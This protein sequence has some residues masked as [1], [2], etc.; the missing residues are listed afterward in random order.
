M[1]AGIFCLGA[2]LVCAPGLAAQHETHEPA[3]GAKPDLSLTTVGRHHHPIQTS[4]AEAQTYFDQGM[5]FIYGF[6]HEEAQRAFEH[7]AALDPASP[8]PLWGVALAVGPNYNLDVDPARE[9]LAYDTIQKALKLA[10]K[11]SQVE[12]DYVAALAV[13]YSGDANPDYKKLGRDYATAMG[14]LSKKY[15]DDL[16]AATL[17]AESLMNLRPWKLWSHEGKPAEGTLEIVRVLE[18]VLARVPNHP[19]ANHYYIHAVEASEHPERALPAAD[20]LGTMVPKAGHLVHMPAHIYI[21]T[22][23]FENA[24]KN[25]VMAAAVDKEYAEKAAKQGSFYDMLYHSHNE[26]FIAA[27]ASMKGSYA[28]AKKAADVMAARLV[29][30]AAKMPM[31]D[32]FILTPIWV[33]A[34]FGKWDEILARPEPSKEL[35]G[36]HAFWRYSRALAFVAR[37]QPDKAQAERDAM[38]AETAQIPADTPFGMQN[39]AKDA[40][41]LAT[42]VLDARIATARKRND[43]AMAHWRKAIEIQDALN[44]DEPPG[45][46][47]PV[48]ESLGA[49]LLAAGNAAEAE[50][51]FREDLERNLRNPRSLFGLTQALRAQKKDV[52]AAWVERQFHAA[53][54]T[55]DTQLKLSDL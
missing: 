13:R 50:K 41:A 43:E 20:R 6:N 3:A 23:D 7:A 14:E 21:R 42:Q 55:A 1:K 49:A 24:T 4:N 16:D 37:S 47:Y 54:R 2:L 5:T 36:T 27:A 22:G 51:V 30:H 53:W 10:E 39:M 38:V 52:D 26:H 44:Y 12:K 31:L 19:G 29:P 8:M 33:D 17:Y 28:Q 45:W 9:K 35:S 15:P 18:S 48:R 11:A 40:F 32:G 34:R 25:N 46:Y